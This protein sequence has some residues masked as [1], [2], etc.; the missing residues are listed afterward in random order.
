[1]CN[2]LYR[3]KMELLLNGIPLV[4][5]HHEAANLATA[6]API[7]RAALVRVA[8]GDELRVRIPGPYIPAF[9]YIQHIICRPD[10]LF[11]G[12]YLHP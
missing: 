11:S 7:S 6:R 8:Q 3:V 4:N 1:M 5:L 9:T 2:I 12:F 10:T